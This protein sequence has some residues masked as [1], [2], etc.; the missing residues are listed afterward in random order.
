MY[1]Y[2]VKQ[3]KYAKC[4]SPA[5]KLLYL[6]GRNPEEAKKDS[7]CS[8]E[9]SFEPPVC[10]CGPKGLYFE[11]KLSRLGVLK[12][13][14]KASACTPMSIIFP[15]ALLVYLFIFICGAAGA[16]L[17]AAIFALPITSLLLNLL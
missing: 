5:I 17:S 7:Y 9:R 16:L 11:K 2:G 10:H 6:Y 15:T 12:R 3:A 4:S 14:L 8:V 1:T 13:N